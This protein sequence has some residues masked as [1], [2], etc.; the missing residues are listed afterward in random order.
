MKRKIIYSLLMVIALSSV[1]CVTLRTQKIR[2]EKEKVY[3]IVSVGQNIYIAESELKNAGYKLIH[4]TAIHPTKNKDYLSQ[5]VRVDD[6]FP[7]ASDTF[8]YTVTGGDSPFRLE[9]PSVLIEASN[10][11]TITKVE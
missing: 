11:G 10:D 6:N 3:S 7:T 9:S 2:S 1:S 4:E 8:F 5:I